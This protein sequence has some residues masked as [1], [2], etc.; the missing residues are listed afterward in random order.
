MTNEFD[1]K[2][3]LLIL[4]TAQQLNKNDQVSI[5]ILHEMASEV[6]TLCKTDIIRFINANQDE[7]F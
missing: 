4:L 7:A 3:N 5:N 2:L 6:I 1:E